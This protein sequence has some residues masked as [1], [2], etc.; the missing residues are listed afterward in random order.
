MEIANKKIKTLAIRIRQASNPPFPKSEDHCTNTADTL[1]FTNY[2]AKSISLT[3]ICIYFQFNGIAL[4]MI[5]S[6]LLTH[7]QCHNTI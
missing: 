2:F 5:I 4:K 1:D 7:P 6:G 3:F